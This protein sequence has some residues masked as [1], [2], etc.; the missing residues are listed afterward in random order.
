MLVRK[1]PPTCVK[2]V[3]NY[4]E[5]TQC[6]FRIV[7]CTFTSYHPNQISNFFS[8]IP[9]RNPPLLTTALSLIGLFGDPLRWHCTELHHNHRMQNTLVN[10]QHGVY[11]GLR[12][13]LE[14][15]GL[16]Y[17]PETMPPSAIMYDEELITAS[18]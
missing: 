15:N 7:R 17:P 14:Q 11:L 10:F 13:R 12:R 5:P 9:K 2:N 8:Y 1:N 16:Y 3:Q 18:L 4:L 6:T